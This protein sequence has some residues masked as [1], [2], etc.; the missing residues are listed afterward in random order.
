MAE[1]LH[2]ASPRRAGIMGLCSGATEGFVEGRG[3]CS[4]TMIEIQ[5]PLATKLISFA[6]KSVSHF[7]LL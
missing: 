5:L 4:R 6:A 3:S 2:N 1:G 7:L